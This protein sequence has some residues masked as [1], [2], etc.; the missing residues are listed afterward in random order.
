MPASSTRRP[1]TLPPHEEAAEERHEKPV[2]VV[3]ILPPLSGQCARD[4]KVKRGEH[5]RKER[6]QQR[7][8]RPGA[9]LLLDP[10]DLRAALQ[11]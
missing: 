5:H 11:H 8:L 1:S 9:A 6:R 4:R 3:G 7:H 2:R 10:L